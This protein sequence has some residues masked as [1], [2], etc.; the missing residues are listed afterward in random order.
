[1][2][3]RLNRVVWLGLALL[4][5]PLWA[6]LSVEE[7]IEDFETFWES[8]KTAYV[9]FELKNKDYGVDWDAIKGDFV[10]RLKESTSD[11]EL[12]AAITEAQT[13]LRDGHCYNGSFSKIR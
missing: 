8:Y 1:M 11:I 3:K 10:N 2:L 6:E 7:R 4:A 9:F 13:L 12:Y 5:A